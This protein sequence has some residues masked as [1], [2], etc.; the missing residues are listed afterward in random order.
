MSRLVIMKGLPASGKTT[1]ALRLVK[2][3]KFKRVSKDDLRAMIDDSKWS[4]S[5]EE[6]IKDIEVM[7]VAGF[8]NAGKNVVVDDTNLAYENIW[9]SVAIQC[10]ADFEVKFFDVPLM[11][12][13]ERDAKRGDK[14]VGAKV[15]QRMYDKYLKPEPPEYSDLKQNCYIF[16]ID[17][18]LAKMNGRSPYDYSKVD[19]DTPNHNIAMIARVLSASGLPI[20]IVSGRTDDCKE[21]T[22][23]WLTDNSIPFTEIFMRKAGDTRKDAIV[24]KEIFD[25]ELKDRYNIWAVFDDRN[26]VVEMWRSLGITCLQ[27]AYGNF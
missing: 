21:E 5:N 16:D 10:N 19:T 11:E 26:Q 7:I 1:E 8:L 3:E 6:S 9:E 23:K 22:T 2:E 25:N 17:G 12:C 20:I 13:I 14:S 27:V 15:I 24:K 4:S 18:T